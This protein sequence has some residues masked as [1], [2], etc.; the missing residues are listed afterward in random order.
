[1]GSSPTGAP[2]RGGLCWNRRFSTDMSLYLKNGARW[3][4]S[5]YGTL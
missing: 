1:M 4:H 5:Y 3:G 2:N